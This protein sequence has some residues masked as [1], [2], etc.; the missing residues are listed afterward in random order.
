MKQKRNSNNHDKNSTFTKN[1][2]LIT[3]GRVSE[4]TIRIKNQSLSRIQCRIEYNEKGWLVSDG[5][6]DK[7]STNGTWLYLL[8]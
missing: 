1:D 3:V 5:D 7:K 6:E 4:A 2:G 8:M